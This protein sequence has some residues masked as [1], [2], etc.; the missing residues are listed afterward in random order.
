M[1]TEL[2]LRRDL[3]S[4]YRI[5]AAHGFNEGV[6]NHLTVVLKH[7]GASEGSA[8]LVIR[9][10]MDWKEVTPESLIIFDNH[11]GAII[12]GSGKIEATAFQIHSAIHRHLPKAKV[13]MHTHMPYATALTSLESGRLR[14]I[15]QNALRFWGRIKYDDVYNGLAQGPSEGD[16]IAASLEDH[17]VLFMANHGVIVTGET[18][19][20][21]W[22]ELYYLERA[23]QNQVLALSTGRPLKEVP[24]DICLAVQQAEAGDLKE[25]G[26]LHFAA[27]KRLLD[28]HSK[29]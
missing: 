24:D 27:Q 15:N 1:N 13:V 4:A 26:D 12:E 16:R 8:S 9:H 23:C 10:G 14:M 5:C 17:S 29:L 7:A 22:H 21:A 25:Y 2:K 28:T 18:I 20:Q 3:A 19:A 11:T 6:C